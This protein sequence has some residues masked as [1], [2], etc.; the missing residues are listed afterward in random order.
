MVGCGIHYSRIISYTACI[1]VTRTIWIYN[2][3]SCKFDSGRLLLKFRRTILFT[4]FV[5]AE[6]ITQLAVIIG[7]CFCCLFL[8]HLIKFAYKNAKHICSQFHIKVYHIPSNIIFWRSCTNICDEYTKVENLFFSV[9]FRNRI[10]FIL[11][12]N[13]P[14]GLVLIG[15]K[16]YVSWQWMLRHCVK[17]LSF[18]FG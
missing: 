8:S 10:E 7:I 13:L 16:V 5:L 9:L 6:E 18:F 12:F 17:E 1:A 3:K 15:L 4:I 14:F 2:Y 11:L